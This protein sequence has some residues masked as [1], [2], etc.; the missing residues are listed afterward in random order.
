MLDKLALLALLIAANGAP[1]LADDLLGRRWSWPLDGGL[2][3][4]DGRRLLGASATLRGLIAA[5][6]TAASLSLLIGHSLAAG[7]LIGLLAMV[8]DGFSSFVK[9]RM[10]LGPGARALGLDQVPESLL[11]LLAVAGEYRLD[12]ID[13]L[14]LVAAFTLFDLAVSRLLYRLNLRKRPY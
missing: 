6:V 7:V 10:G 4:S 13:I 1:I 3:L 8:G 11:P 14:V 12:A 2:L 5:I 9:R